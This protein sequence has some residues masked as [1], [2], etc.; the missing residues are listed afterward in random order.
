MLVNQEC[1]LICQN[2]IK[3]STTNLAFEFYL[4]ILLTFPFILQIYI[5]NQIPWGN[6]HVKTN[7]LT[8]SSH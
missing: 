2:G 7:G 6:H 4:P 1:P 5:E 8:H 3:L